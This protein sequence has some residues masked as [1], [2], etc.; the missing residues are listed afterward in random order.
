MKRTFFAVMM[1]C[2]CMMATAQNELKSRIVEDGGTG[3]YK[4]I[5]KEV[6]TLQAH[7]VF[8]PQDLTVFNA[9]KA[10]PVLVWGNGACTNSPW[11]H[12]KFLNEIA[13]HGYIVLATGYIPM[14]EEPYRGPM[15]TTQQQIESI[16][17]AFA[18]NADPQS[19]YYQKIDTK[20]ICVAGMS[21]GGLQ[22]LFNCA[23]SRISAMMICNSGL[24]KQETMRQAVG[25]MPMPPKE[26]LKELH[27]PIIYILGGKEDIAYENGMDDFHRIE[28]VPAIAIN[29][30]VGHG[31][32]Y[33]Q[34]H[35]GEFT[36]PALAWLN[37]QLKGDQEAAK[38]FV[39]DDCGI[40]KRKDWTIEKNNMMRAI[41]LQP[42]KKRAKPT[43]M[44]GIERKKLLNDQWQFVLNDSNFTKAQ[45]VTLPH[46]WSILQRFDKNT[47]AGNEGAYLPTGKGWYRRVLTLSKAYE[48]KKMRL[49][50]EGVY[51][52]SRVYVNG[53]EA[54]GWPY[55]YSSFWVDATPYL[56]VGRNEIIVSVDNSQQKNCRWYS[57]SGIY[58]NV[59]F[60][61]TPMTYIDDWSVQVTTPDIHHV[62]L[63]ATVIREDG[64]TYPLQRTI[65]VEQPRLWSPDDPYLYEA[66]LED[67]E[68][69][70][71]TVQYG[72]R[73]IE[74]DAQR[75][76]LLNGKS[77]KLNGACLHHDNGILGAAAYD[78]AE[79]RKAKLAKEAG[80]NA[81]RTSHNPPSESFLKACDEVGLLVIDEAFDGWRDKKNEHDYHKLIDQWW[82]RDIDALICRDRLHP[83]VFCW[84][85]GNEVIERKKI[86]VIK[87]AHNMAARIHALDAQ[88][89]P[90]TSA[91]AAWD[92]DWDIYDPLAAQHD[93][94]G[95]NY[96]I[97][98]AESDHERVPNRVMM[99]TESYPRDAW[100]NYRTSMDH[101]YIFGDFVWT[102]ID[103][104][105]ESGIG[106]YYYEGEVPGESWERPLYPWH[107]A[108]C[109]DV[110][111]IGQRK[112]I[113]YYRSLLWNGGSTYMA[114]REPDG[115]HGKVK[116]TMW[117]TWPTQESWTWPAWENKPIEVEVYS[118][119]PTVSLYLNDKLIGEQPVK[120]KKATFTLPYQPGTLRAQAGN[121]RC[122]IQTAGKPANIR[123]TA[124][125][126]SMKA[127][128]LAFIAVEI[129][130]A[131]GRIVP[132]S[133]E[134]LTFTVSGNATLLAAGNADIKD[135]D[136]YF[137]NQHRAW[138]G[139]ALAIIRN[140]GKRGK[141]TL[142]VTANGLP[143]ARITLS[144]Q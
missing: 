24:F 18:Q 138:Q 77:I 131:E 10:L 56:H 144:A 122:E 68:G 128:G 80:F 88:N 110:D 127:N 16:D 46:D 1:M 142:T 2:L 66:E 15:S 75:G 123:L 70:R 21:C 52:N 105:G 13:S 32:T 9:K 69:D 30:P 41:S 55:G 59:W 86:E 141:A 143:S 8:V 106:R 42:Q 44:V 6:G 48:G 76:L 12:Y 113:S 23:D 74:Y 94:V 140:N 22:S 5:M 17:W 36:I 47:P 129:V 73:T 58:R 85:I 130:D 96:M 90:V 135:E 28:H 124:D 49:Y 64:S 60:V 136:P 57:G 11:E 7:T 37:W 118:E 116:T 51:M 14:N 121:E 45:A 19:P 43:K 120:E 79:Y 126:N 54:G 115:Y 40:L 107:A 3:P 98:K 34:A 93:I 103:Y 78:D 26:K 125:R 111:L 71:L 91:L 29:Y 72:I 112:P 82:Q 119:Q 4:A 87:T 97:F 108:Y 67:A 133:S 27:T 114:V 33:R 53:H 31:G 132:T 137:D 65:V 92:R 83:S 109:G 117:S 84:S 139:R 61:I 50:F 38:M 99:Q 39:G 95:Y 81:V 101:S 89:R 35:G 104:L 100:R 62:N 102:G 63:S 25:G 134:G 20:H